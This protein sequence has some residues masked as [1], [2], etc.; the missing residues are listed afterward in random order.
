MISGLVAATALVAVC[1][2]AV[3]TGCAATKKAYIPGE[4]EELYGSWYNGENDESVTY[5]PDGHF[6]YFIGNSKLPRWH[7]TFS[8]VEKWRD[9][10]GVIWNSMIVEN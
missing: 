2:V 9:R 1:F 3:L 4:L 5:K 10:E 7:G 8:I 6:E